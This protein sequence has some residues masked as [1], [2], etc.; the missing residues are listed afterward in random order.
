MGLIL[1][2]YTDKGSNR[3]CTCNG[4]T[5]RFDRLCVVN[6]DGPFEPS[7]DCPAVVLKRGALDGIAILRPVEAKSRH[8]MFGGNYASTSD[9]RFSNAI[10]AITGQRF[11]GAVAVHD[12]IEN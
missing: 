4:V 5:N 10:E 9:S 12:R 8:T 7:N 1:S 2:V 6:V 3:D 11:Y